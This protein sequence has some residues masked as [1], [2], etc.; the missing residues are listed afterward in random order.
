MAILTWGDSATKEY[1]TSLHGMHVRTHTQN[2]FLLT[3][4]V[5]KKRTRLWKGKK[6]KYKANMRVN[7]T[8]EKLSIT[9]G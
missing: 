7:Y 4:K 5:R 2:P 9:N 3:C 8:S 1:K 6:G